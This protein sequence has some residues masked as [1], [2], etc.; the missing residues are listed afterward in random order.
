MLTAHGA[1][2]VGQAAEKRRP[3]KGWI[4][5]FNRTNM[6]KRVTLH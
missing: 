4:G 6:L 1:I 2:D 5:V 3:T